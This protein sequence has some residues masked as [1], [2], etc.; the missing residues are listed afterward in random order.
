MDKL[1]AIRCF[2]RVAETRSFAAAAHD[3]DV[4]PSV[5]SKTIASLEKEIAFRLL[6]RTTRHVSLTEDGARYYDRCKRL[7][8][9]LDEAE[10]LTRKGMNRPVGRLTLGLHPALNHILMSRVDEF[11]AKYPEIALETT[12]SSVVS[13]LIE[14]RLDVLV[15]IGDLPNSNFGMQRI[16]TSHFVLVATKDYLRLNGVPQ[17]PAD[18]ASHSIIVSS[19]R[20]SPSF[21]QW[22]LTR[23]NKTETIYAP[24]RLVSREGIHM[25][26]ACL[27]GA[28][29]GRMFEVVARPLIADGDLTQVLSEWSLDSFPIQAV[30]P[31]SKDVPAKARVLVNFLRAILKEEQWWMRRGRNLV[32]RATP[33]TSAWR[34]QSFGT[35]A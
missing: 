35:G 26:E 14:D 30:F 27:S 1:R 21:V 11:L 6:N 22:T 12:T 25:R 20:D 29:V 28:G 24:A 10:R 3:L 2:C 7:L 15:T 18:L 16:G 4:V 17:T 34:G 5:L 13:T 33:G 9:E 23:G 19:R 31:S 32:T 8:V